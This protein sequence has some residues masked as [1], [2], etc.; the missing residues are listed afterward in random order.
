MYVADNNKRYAGRHVHCPML[1][2]HE[3]MFVCLRPSVTYSL[4]EQIVL[5]GTALAHHVTKHN[6]PFHNILSIAPQLSVSQKAKER[7]LKMAM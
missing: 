1:Q 7:S 5:A 3:R 6:T 4:A 2:R